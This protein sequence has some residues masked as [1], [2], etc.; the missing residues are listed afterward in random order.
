[1]LSGRGPKT[2]GAEMKKSQLIVLALLIIF[3]ASL[4][5]KTLPSEN[6]D[7]KPTSTI[8]TSVVQIVNTA[9]TSEVTIKKPSL[10][11]GKRERVNL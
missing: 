4:S 5:S 9:S 3:A 1:M 2:Q 7:A 10:N 6:E 11:W 8:S